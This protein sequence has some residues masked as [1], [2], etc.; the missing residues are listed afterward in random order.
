MKVVSKGVIIEI[1]EICDAFVGVSV[2]ETGRGLLGVSYPRR[3]A[4]FF[5]FA[6]VLGFDCVSE[7]KYRKKFGDTY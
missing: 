4:R 6:G 5:G 7:G 2:N 3:V 1:R